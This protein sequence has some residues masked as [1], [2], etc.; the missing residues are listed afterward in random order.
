MHDALPFQT[1]SNN[2]LKDHVITET[3]QAMP[4]ITLNS[5]RK[6]YNF[7]K[8]FN[9]NEMD[10]KHFNEEKFLQDLANTRIANKICVQIPTSKIYDV[11]H[12]HVTSTLDK[13]APMRNLT[14][15]ELAIKLKP[16]LTTGII[17]SISKKT[18]YYKKF[19]S[20]KLDKWYNQYKLYRDKIS[21]F[22][23]TSKN[24]HYNAYFHKFS[25]NSKKV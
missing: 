2:E 17:K 15:P 23:R 20:T 22:L 11:F 19:T 3:P 6:N 14:K 9:I 13:H 21:H 25:H 1:I 12:E 18:F 16:W 24:M 7:S 4:E 5:L 10:Y 8:N